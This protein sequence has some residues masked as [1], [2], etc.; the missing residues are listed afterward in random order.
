MAR[1]QALYSGMKI[2]KGSAQRS[3]R[4]RAL[5]IP[6][7]LLRVLA[8][9]RLEERPTLRAHGAGL[10]IDT[11]ALKPSEIRVINHGT[12]CVHTGI[13]PAI[14]ETGRELKVL[15]DGG[16]KESSRPASAICD[17]SVVSVERA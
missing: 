4:I 6:S 14:Q 15:N 2:R 12:V 7:S 8:D 5:P 3:A 16:A 13:R 17:D 10:R 9:A 11:V 1:G